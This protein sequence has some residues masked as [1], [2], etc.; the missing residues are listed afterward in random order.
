MTGGAGFV[1]NRVL[2]ELL[3][4]GHA[5]VNADALTDAASLSAVWS[6]E[7]DPGYTLEPADICDGEGMARL[8]Q[9]HRPDAVLHLA[10]DQGTGTSTLELRQAMEVNAMGTLTLLEAA[11]Q[12][13]ERSDRPEGFR[14]LHASSADVLASLGERGQ[15][16]EGAAHAPATP[17]GAS[18]AAGDH[19]VSAWWQS[20]GLPTLTCRSGQSF[21]PWQHPTALIPLTLMRALRGEPI[22]VAGQGGQ[23]RDWL[24][25]E[26]HARGLVDVLERGHVGETYN[27]SAGFEM[28]EIDLVRALC[29]LLQ[30]RRPS[31]TPYGGLVTF[32]PSAMGVPFRQALDGTKLR[33]ELGWRPERSFEDALGDTIDWYL[34]HH[35]WWHASAP[36]AADRQEAVA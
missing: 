19:L 6:L 23:A 3:A 12:H 17:H 5:V 35:G 32:G 24:P 13:W 22:P 9:R 10:A 27:I 20:F 16:G 30:V 25:V 21:G 18:K 8:F 11:R 26:D 1:G 33:G 15:A 36:L 29:R 31:P 2:G 28:R 34:A 14:F 7:E 4:R